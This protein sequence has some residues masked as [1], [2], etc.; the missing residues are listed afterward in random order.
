MI[1]GFDK[2]G[3]DKKSADE[4]LGDA[5]TQMNTCLTELTDAPGMT[6][7]AHDLVAS[8]SD[9]TKSYLASFQNKA[10]ARKSKDDAFAVWSKTGWSITESMG[11]AN[12]EIIDPALEKA[13]AANDLVA[14][15]KWSKNGDSLDGDV[16][17][18]FFCCCVSMQ[19][20]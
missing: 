10:A 9:V 8:G 15:A 14:F 18:P 5:I 3:E 12:T 2:T 1:N 20:T 19:S 6:V 4:R 11:K 13:K 16:F 17:Q 7:E